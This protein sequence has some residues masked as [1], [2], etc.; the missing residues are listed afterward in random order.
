MVAVLLTAWAG[1]AKPRAVS[2][3]PDGSQ[4]VAAASSLAMSPRPSPRAP[5]ATDSIAALP[6]A[7]DNETATPLQTST[8]TPQPTRQ[9]ASTPP[10]A[11][12]SLTLAELLAR[13][14]TA[15]EQRAGYDRSLFV[16]WIDADGDGCDT[17]REV[18][19]DES[20][21]KV[22]VGAS[23]SLS[24]GSWLSLYDGLSF[25]DPS[26]LDI[27][28][29]VPLAEAWDS[30]ANAWTADRR[31]RF[32]ND[33]DVSWSLIAVS[34]SSNR[35]KG[36]QDPADWLP[37]SS[38]EFCSYLGDWLA[39]KVRWSLSVDTGERAAVSAE[40]TSC[41]DTRRPVMLAP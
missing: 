34:A 8:V 20:L 22:A 6:A 14:P 24:G 27:D 9:P 16:H 30:G 1:G 4:G 13:L 35:S 10:P 38:S 15:P 2:V 39:V 29:M 7:S 3:D 18:L 31:K 25:T 33:L 5:Q 23:C 40:I 17:R 21:S 32:A 26:G 19:I 37:P 12:G 36:D 11:A 28:H 41:P